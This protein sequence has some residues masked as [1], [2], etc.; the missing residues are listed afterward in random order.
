MGLYKTIG[1]TNMKLK[2]LKNMII[3]RLIDIKNIG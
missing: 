3:E 2:R 1:E